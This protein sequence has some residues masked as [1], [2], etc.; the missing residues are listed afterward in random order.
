MYARARRRV[1]V[2]REVLLRLRQHRQ[3]QLA[4]AGGEIRQHAM[5]IEGRL[6]SAGVL[7]AFARA[8][9]NVIQRIASVRA[10]FAERLGRIDQGLE[11]AAAV[12]GSSRSSLVTAS[13]ASQPAT[14]A[15]PGGRLELE[16]ASEPADRH[17]GTP[18]AA[19]RPAPA[20]PAGRAPRRPARASE[21]VDGARAL[22][23]VGWGPLERL[24]PG[25]DGAGVVLRRGQDVALQEQRGGVRRA[26]PIEGVAARRAA[27]RAAA[28]SSRCRPSA[29]R[30]LA[31]GSITASGR[32]R[33]RRELR[34]ERRR[35][36][37]LGVE[38]GPHGGRHRAEP[39]ID[40]HLG[41][42]REAGVAPR[43][44][45]VD[46]H[47]LALGSPAHHGGLEVVVHERRRSQLW[48]WSRTPRRWNKQR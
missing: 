14:S 4:L 10:S 28:P 36:R 47:R 13:S 41:L 21:V 3:R 16:R 37:P 42:Q 45:G 25:G 19:G 22:G 17:V 34:H 35:A 5:G 1:V 11:R 15:G 44:P 33:R 24:A 43:R 18:V 27:A 40:Q 12:V 23:P 48:R 2:E 32:H 31:S 7:A 26:M 29:G 39:R 6:R 8:S 38:R 30:G 20:R 9:R 46:E